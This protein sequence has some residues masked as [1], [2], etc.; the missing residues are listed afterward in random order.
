ML[1]VIVLVSLV[2]VPQLANAFL[3]PAVGR[4]GSFL[5]LIVDPYHVIIPTDSP[6]DPTQVRS[7]LIFDTASHPTHISLPF[8]L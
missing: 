4:L 6:L 8:S 5:R 1:L 2:S 7:S 3:S